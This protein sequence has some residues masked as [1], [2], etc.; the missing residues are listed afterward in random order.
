MTN[1]NLISN[2]S[3]VNDLR[4]ASYSH[5]FSMDQRQLI[6]DYLVSYQTYGTNALPVWP[7]V[8]KLLNGDRS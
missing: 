8:F 7:G 3:L 1:T 6:R 2:L 5:Y 4:L